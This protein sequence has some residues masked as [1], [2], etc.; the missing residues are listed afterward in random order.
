MSEGVAGRVLGTD[1]ATPLEFWVAV[2]PGAH[3]QLDD[4]V[5][6]DRTLPDGETVSIYGIVSQVRARHEGARFDSDVF[7]I[8]DGVLPAE[9]AEAAQVQLT[10]IV[11]ETFVPP[12]PGT[13]VRK[14]T[15][16]ER[17]AALDF[18]DVD[19]RL[20][21]G[22]SR[23]ND[24]IWLDLDFLDGTKGAHVNIAGISGVA[25]KTSYATFLLYSLF[26]S[27]VLGAEAANT[28]GVD[29]QREG[30]GPAVPRPPQ[31]RARRGPAARATPTSG[32]EASP[33]RSVGIL[34]PPRKGDP[35]ATPDTGA[36]LPG[37]A[38]VLLDHRRV[39]RAAAAA[40]PV[41]R[42]RGRA[43]AVHDRGA[44]GDR[45]AGRDRPRPTPTPTGRCA[46]TAG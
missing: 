5:A 22:L 10:R 2:G 15:D 26:T 34:A 27:G 17:D 9:V 13:E 41:R 18:E 35:N 23:E 21:A 12:L 24:P 29:L 1:D 14:A 20:A 46:S 8:A 28:K 32:L 43:P 3:L 38:P 25:T 11:P 40:V 4:V 7:L 39:L 33:F 42:R 44:V 19:R 45:P 30:R 16:A 6:L 37:G 36:R 31:H